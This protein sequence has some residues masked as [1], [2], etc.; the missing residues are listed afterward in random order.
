MEYWLFAHRE[1]VT[2][3][4]RAFMLGTLAF[5]CWSIQRDV[6]RTWPRIVEMFKERNGE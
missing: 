6:R 5:C 4:I 1:L 2:W 3:I